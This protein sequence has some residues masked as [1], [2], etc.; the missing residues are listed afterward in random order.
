MW[1]RQS[2][3]YTHASI[4]CYVFNSNLV[5]KYAGYR[6]FIRRLTAGTTRQMNAQDTHQQ[7]P[8]TYKLCGYGANQLESCF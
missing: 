1:V 3:Q 6:H 8:Y 2:R 7:S 5:N 4:I